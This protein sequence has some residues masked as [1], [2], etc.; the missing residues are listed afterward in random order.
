MAAADSEEG[1]LGMAG[2]G[3]LPFGNPR[4]RKRTL[5]RDPDGAADPA[6][7]VAQVC[8]VRGS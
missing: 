4:S 2:G 8:P 7:G 6:G 5:A 3:R 1:R